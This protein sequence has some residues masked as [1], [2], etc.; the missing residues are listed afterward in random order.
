MRTT[1]APE[2]HRAEANTYRVQYTMA[3]TQSHRGRIPVQATLTLM[4]TLRTHS[5]FM[6]LPNCRVVLR[7]RRASR[8]L[9]RLVVIVI[10]L[11][12]QRAQ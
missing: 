7:S 1:Q 11:E 5:L 3:N 12:A 2:A 4:L 10:G 9:T 8:R 6:V